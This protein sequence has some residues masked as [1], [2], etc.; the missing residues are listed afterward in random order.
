MRVRRLTLLIVTSI[1]LTHCGD[2]EPV[3]DPLACT[4]NAAECVDDERLRSCVDGVWSVRRCEDECA[5]RPAPGGS[6]GCNLLDGPDECRC[7]QIRVCEQD[8]ELSCV[9]SR[10]IL[11]CVDGRA[12]VALCQCSD[13]NHV[14]LGCHEEGDRASCACA[15]AGTPCTEPVWD[16]CVGVSSVARCENG[17]WTITACADE[18]APAEALGCVFSPL[19]DG[20]TCACAES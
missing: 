1:A 20:G 19:G 18:C 4:A 14:S 5:E 8:A 6:L 15:S 13:P 16:E 9:S 10:H 17:V 3:P 2:D 12:E 7:S 11:D